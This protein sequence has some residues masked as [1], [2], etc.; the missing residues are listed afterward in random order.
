MTL[1]E[2]EQHIIERKADGYDLVGRKED[3]QEQI[4][5]VNEQLK[6]QLDIVEREIAGNNSRIVA[7][8]VER[9]RIKE[10]MVNAQM[11]R[12]ADREAA[13][14]KVETKKVAKVVTKDETVAEP[15]QEE[16]KG[17]L[18]MFKRKKATK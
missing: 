5:R 8:F 3:L 18:G 10:E 17:I 2:I 13:K 14:Q 4:A 15:K 12:V 11:K 6:E 9:K 7:L 16:K 1:P